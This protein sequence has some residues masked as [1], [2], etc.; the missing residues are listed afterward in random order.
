MYSDITGI[1]VKAAQ[2]SNPF[3]NK[4]KLSRN[5]LHV[6]TICLILVCRPAHVKGLG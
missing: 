1:C 6:S 3:N 5:I 2:R 4:H